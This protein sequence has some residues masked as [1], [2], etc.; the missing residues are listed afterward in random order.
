MLELG[1][2]NLALA[3]LDRALALDANHAIAL[4]RR[5][6]AKLELRRP[7]AET[8]ADCDRALALRPTHPEVRLIH[9]MARR[10]GGG[11]P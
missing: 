8:L 3:D 7:R 2:P 11:S 9:E 4:A 5:C 1:R 10:S 6:S